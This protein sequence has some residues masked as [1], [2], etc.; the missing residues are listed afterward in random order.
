[1]SVALNFEM[2]LASYYLLFF[3][4][5]SY[6]DLKIELSDNIGNGAFGALFKGSYKSHLCAVK[7]LT[8]HAMTIT[9]GGRW[10]AT[11][12]IQPEALEAFQQE[13]KCLKLL[14]HENIVRYYTT[15]IEPSSNL[16]ML[17]M[18]LMDCN[19]KQYLKEKQE[20]K[21]SLPCQLGLCLNISEGLKYLHSQEVIHHDLCDVNILIA[22]EDGKLPKAKLADFGKSRIAL[23]HRATITGFAHGPAYLPNEAR[24]YP[25][26]HRFALD[27]YSYGVVATQILQMKAFF[28]NKAEFDSAY[29][30][31][32][33]S[34]TLKD[35]IISCLSEECSRQPQTAEIVS[36]G[37]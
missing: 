25:Y 36:K 16:P 20:K 37:M 5:E 30:E 1:M 13:S 14:R 29:E 11:T 22:Q 15:M 19:L 24:E 32:S 18:E 12:G 2:P 3:F 35:T 27:I 23:D 7:L 31:I 34:L 9:T 28:K 17:V 33:E 8:H 10:D 26:H 21:L 6:G 4:P